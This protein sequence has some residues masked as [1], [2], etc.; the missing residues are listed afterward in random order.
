MTPQA[1]R[2][3]LTR[4]EL[5]EGLPASGL[6]QVM[7]RLER[8]LRRRVGA[9]G[10]CFFPA[11]IWIYT[12]SAARGLP[13]RVSRHMS[14]R[15]R[16]HWHID[17]LLP[18]GRVAAVRA[19]ADR[20]EGECRLHSSLAARFEE[21]PRGFGSSDCGCRSHLV[22]AGKKVLRLDGFLPIL[23]ESGGSIVA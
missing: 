15:K 14:G 23:L 1:Q 10:E 18:P 17:Y 7:F 19:V 6:Y 2:K 9:L 12:G 11:G 5:L 3:A 13:A 4:D 8:P 21:G 22:Y 16:L 20:G